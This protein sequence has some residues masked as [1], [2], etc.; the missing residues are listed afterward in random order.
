MSSSLNASCSNLRRS[1]RTVYVDCYCSASSSYYG[2][3]WVNGSQKST[4]TNANGGSYSGTT[5]ISWDCPGAFSSRTI[6]CRLQY[7]DYKGYST[8]NSYKYPSTGSLGA[9]TVTATFDHNDGSGS[10]DT[11]TETYDSTWVLPAEPTRNGYTFLGWFDDPDNG[12]Q[13][14]DTDTVAI[15]ADITLYAHWERAGFN[16]YRALNGV[17]GQVAEIYRVSNGVVEQVT[18]VYRVSNG[19]VKQ[20]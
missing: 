14:L 19:T 2:K 3:V 6:T 9:M 11:E 12:N 7:Q 17:I 18:E 5:T 10:T 15:D 20:I 4:W 1:G 13:I 16:I 8:Q